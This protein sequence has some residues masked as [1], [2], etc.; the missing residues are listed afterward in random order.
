MLCCVV[1]CC[2][3]L[4]CV[5]LCCGVGSRHGLSFG[6]I[7]IT[8]V[9]GIK[10]QPNANPRQRTDAHRRGISTGAKMREL[11]SLDGEG[12]ENATDTANSALT[13]FRH[14]HT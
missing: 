13:H 2:V 11:F 1:L 8:V 9:A 6:V 12:E 10:E 7:G 4:C 3:V 5:V 14:I